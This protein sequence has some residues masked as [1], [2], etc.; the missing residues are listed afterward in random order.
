MK[1]LYIQMLFILFSLIQVSY[2][3]SCV[4]NIDGDFHF[5]FEQLRS[6]Y[7]VVS[8]AKQI[9]EPEDVDYLL[10]YAQNLSNFVRS[11]LMGQEPDEA[12]TS[13]TMFLPKYTD[14]I[15]DCIGQ[16]LSIAIQQPFSH[17]ESF[18]I[19]KYNKSQHYLPHWDWFYPESNSTTIQRTHTIFA[20][21]K[22]AK[23]GGTTIFP[24]IDIETSAE[25][26]SALIWENTDF[27]GNGEKLML[28]GGTKVTCDDGKIGLNVWFQNTCWPEGH[29]KCNR[30]LTKKKKQETCFSPFQTEE[31]QKEIDKLKKEIDKLKKDDKEIVKQ[32]QYTQL[33]VQKM[34]NITIKK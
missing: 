6:E 19:T 20:Y 26:G 34:L 25:P 13:S 22:T 12:R 24:K 9:I 3:I 1:I 30:T 28:H 16:R 2:S 15:L 27:Y 18:Q 10:K 21:L 23:C 17:M 32:I 11:G 8:L 7:P 29:E 4:R 14:P 33:I 31:N 5:Q